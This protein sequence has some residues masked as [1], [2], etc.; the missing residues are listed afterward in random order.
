MAKNQQLNAP[1]CHSKSTR[2]QSVKSGTGPLAAR[3]HAAAH[4]SSGLRWLDVDPTQPDYNN[5][6]ASHKLWVDK[7]AAGFSHKDDHQ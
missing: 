3:L 1:P 7:I 2:P 4:Q 6:Y 5:L